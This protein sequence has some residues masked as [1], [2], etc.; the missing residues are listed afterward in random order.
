MLLI[1]WPINGTPKQILVVIIGSLGGGDAGG[2]LGFRDLC[3]NMAIV[4]NG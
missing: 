3:A 4:I 2:G 1:C